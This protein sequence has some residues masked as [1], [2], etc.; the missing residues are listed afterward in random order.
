MVGQ[1][2]MRCGWGHR[3]RYPCPSRCSIVIVKRRRS[4]WRCAGCCCPFLCQGCGPSADMDFELQWHN[5]GR[6]FQ[7]LKLRMDDVY[8]L[9]K[10]FKKMDL[11]ERT[12]PEGCSRVCQ[13]TPGGQRRQT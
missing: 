8:L 13:R 9:W 12:H 5:H 2:A 1:C 10:V 11:G 4:C 3:V 6:A 7:A